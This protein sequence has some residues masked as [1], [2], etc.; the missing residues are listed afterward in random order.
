MTDKNIKVLGN[1]IA[2]IRTGNNV[3]GQKNYT[4]YSIKNDTF[5]LGWAKHSGNNVKKYIQKIY[6]YDEIS[7]PQGSLKSDIDYV[8]WAIRIADDNRYYYSHSSDPF[9]FSCSTL[10]AKALYECGYFKTDVC[11]ANGAA[12]G[13]NDSSPLHKALFA[14]GFK[15]YAFANTKMQAGDVLIV[16]P[17][18]VAFCVSGNTMVAANGNGD[19]TDRS[20]TAI[21]TYDYRLVGTPKWIFRLPD[22]KIHRSHS[23]VNKLDTAGI[24]DL[25]SK[26]WS[27]WKPNTAQKKVLLKLVDSDLGHKAQEEFFAS[28]AK[29]YVKPCEQVTSNAQVGLMYCCLRLLKSTTFAD[30]VLKQM[31]GTYTLTNM[32]KVIKAN[33][34]SES[35]LEKLTLCQTWI[36]KYASTS[37]STT[38]TWKRTG[39]ATC[40][41]NGV[42]VRSTPEEK[43]GNI[44]GQLN[45]GQRFEVDGKITDGWVHVKVEGL[46][47]GYMYKQ[48][49]KYD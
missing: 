42:N 3:Y 15:K 13:G 39:T 31:N 11:P 43:S 1:I 34:P 32:M 23:T 20:A 17:Y 46:G 9:S 38:T 18:H 19:M 22:S 35:L 37:T 47:I 6:N 48:W 26:D 27:A 4:A 14:A 24:K 5:C 21:T 36:K 29:S 25:L 2:G 49:V 45:K 44:L 41:A 30:K 16:T 7:I 10:V 40:N 8:R 12:I 33:K 28:K